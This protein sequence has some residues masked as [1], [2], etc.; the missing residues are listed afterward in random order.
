VLIFGFLDAG[1]LA[2]ERAFRTLYKQLVE[3]LHKGEYTL[4][5]TFDAR[6]PLI[7]WA[8]THAYFSWSVAPMYVT[9]I[10][11]VLAAYSLGWLNFVALPA[12]H[13]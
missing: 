5:D 11:L 1:Y 3:K 2:Q 7:G 9:L 6:A 13:T 4:A 12:T 10:V 8:R